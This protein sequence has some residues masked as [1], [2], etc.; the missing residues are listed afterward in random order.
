MFGLFGK[1]KGDKKGSDNVSR[2]ISIAPGH[3]GSS[4][5]LSGHNSS[6]SLVIKHSDPHPTHTP[7]QP[8]PAPQAQPTPAAAPAIDLSQYSPIAKVHAVCAY[9]PDPGLA[10]ADS[11]IPFLSFEEGDVIEV[12]EM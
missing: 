1:K 3:S 7:A 12:L 4:S 9:T 8:K 10:Q 2:P 6:S 11:D 5:S